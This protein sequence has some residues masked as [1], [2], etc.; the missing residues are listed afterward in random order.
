MEGMKKLGEGSII[1]PSAKIVRPEV[2][3]IGPNC[4]IDDFAFIFGGTG[5]RIGSYVHIASFVSVIGGGELVIGNYAA[6]AAGARLI[7]GTDQYQGGSRMSAALPIDQRNVR[8][9]R[10]VIGKDAF[11]GTN[12]VVHPGV[13][14]GEGAI[15]GSCS[16]VL[17]DCDPWTIYTGV[18]CK[19][20]GT[21]PRVTR[22]DI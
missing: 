8:L 18:P 17:R 3:E 15:I 4:M 6:V 19:P 13:T 16:L 12:A 10:I 14:I 22:P 5:I 9:D 20:I 7:T 1:Y 2:I 11:V 21:R